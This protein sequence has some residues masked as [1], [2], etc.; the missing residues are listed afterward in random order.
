MADAEMAVLYYISN[1][2]LLRQCAKVRS[3][4][5]QHL[6]HMNSASNMF[7]ANVHRFLALTQLKSPKCA[8]DE[9]R[10]TFEYQ[11]VLVT[12]QEAYILF[13]TADS[14]WGKAV[15]KYTEGYLRL[16]AMKKTESTATDA[17]KEA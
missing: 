1:L 14:L 2:L 15:T 7:K 13:D 16:Q 5:E 10:T 11:L 9:T 17:I 8:E 12:L 3:L 4:C 6:I